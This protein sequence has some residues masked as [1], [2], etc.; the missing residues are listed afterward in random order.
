[1]LRKGLKR[2]L[3]FLLSFC[4]DV[5]NEISVRSFYHSYYEPGGYRSET[6]TQY[7]SRMAK[8]GEIEKKVVNGKAVFLVSA[9]GEKLMDEIIPLQKL[10]SKRWDGWWRIVIFD[11][12]EKN[13]Y[14]RDRV[15]KKL[16]ELGFG[17]WQESVY[18]SSHP[19]ADEMNE[20]F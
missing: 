20:Y 6:V 5:Y 13:K 15:R 9:K 12:E 14:L 19:L 18:I 3:L 8:V 4:A 1:M 11:I 17:K 7:L 16:L 2:N 10:G